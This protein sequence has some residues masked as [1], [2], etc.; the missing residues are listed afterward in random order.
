MSVRH[1]A[2]RFRAQRS[3]VYPL[4]LGGILLLALAAFSL[5]GWGFRRSRAE[6][7]RIGLAAFFVYLLVCATAH[8]MALRRIDG[9]AKE[10][11][12]TVL[13]RFAERGDAFSFIAPIRWNGAILAPEGVYD[14]EITPFRRRPPELKFYPSAAENSFAISQ[15]IVHVAKYFG[16]LSASRK[17]TALTPMYGR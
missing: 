1:Q 3:A 6:H 15:S 17:V 13:T 7:G 12:I 2:N 8:W 16:S 11:G 14:G 4:L 10:R 5:N 9:F